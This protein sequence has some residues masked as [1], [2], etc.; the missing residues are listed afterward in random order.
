MKSLFQTP[1]GIPVSLWKAG[2][3]QKYLFMGSCFTENIG[4]KMKEMKFC[5]DINPFGILYN[6]LSIADALQRLI[7]TVPFQESDLVYHGGLWHSYLHHGSFSS[8]SSDSVVEKI[9]HRLEESSCFLA[10]ADFLLLTFG[11]AWVYELKGTGK[12][13]SNCHKIP[14]AQFNRFRLS[15]PEIIHACRE[16]LEKLWLVNPAVKIVF[17]VSPIRHLKDGAVENQLSKASLLLAV[18]ALV[19]DFGNER[20][21]YFPAYEL[22][23]DEL[24]DYRF[25]AEDMI[26]LTP[27]TVGYIWERFMEWIL[28]EK[29]AG[30]M[31]E[32]GPLRNAEDHRPLNRQSPE[33]LLFLRKMMEKTLFLSHKYNYLDFSVEKAYFAQEIENLKRKERS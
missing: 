10:E 22:V 21:A 14:A 2:Y 25:Y 3:P 29:T 5:V 17:T 9:N 33:Y 24:R 30:M 12:I 32:I 13:V 1:V 19:Q 4:L 15:V 26:H 7:S 6:P 20:C 18:D 31:K 8:P 16:M 11:T 28:D 23:M 27:V